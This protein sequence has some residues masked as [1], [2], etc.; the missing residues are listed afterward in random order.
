MSIS[1]P[2]FYNSGPLGVG[3]PAPASGLTFLLRDDFSIARA[4][5][6]S[7]PFNADVVGIWG[8]GLDTVSGQAISGG[9]LV[10]TNPNSSGG[11]KDPSLWISTSFTRKRGLV[12]YNRIKPHNSNLF[13]ETGYTDLAVPP[14][15][16]AAAYIIGSSFQIRSYRS[17]TVLQ[18]F[19]FPYIPVTLDAY[20]DYYQILGSAGAL[21]VVNNQLVWGDRYRTNTPIYFGSS[22]QPSSIAGN[23]RYK[24][25]RF[26][27]LEANG[28]ST[29][30]DDNVSTSYLAGSVSAGATFNHQ[31]DFNL[32]WMHTNRG[33][34]G[35]TNVDFR[36]QSLSP[37][38]C[39]RISIS[40][41]GTITLSEI[42]ND[43]VTLVATGG[44]T[45]ANG[46]LVS[47]QASGNA[48]RFRNNVTL[49]QYTSDGSFATATLGRLTNIATGGVVSGVWTFPYDLTL[50]A[51]SSLL[52]VL[53]QI[54]A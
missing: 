23:L 45:V 54:K 1:S 20:A 14:T 40:S 36:I 44:S 28:I 34:A 41:A 39:W 10:Y 12:W 17:A 51:N 16:P 15:E 46:N 8:T 18:S 47:V 30:S 19:G 38:N 50:P 52:N 27:D 2:L 21:Y 53:N 7:Y 48:I 31:A 6:F 13:I 29:W 35:S 9:E 32:Q 22:L 5:P 24:T 49:I 37:L 26:I 43:I 4:S 33:S 11:F 3:H 25:T 42:V